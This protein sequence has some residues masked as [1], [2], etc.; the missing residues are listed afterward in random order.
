MTTE[1]AQL[2]TRVGQPAESIVDSDLSRDDLIQL[3]KRTALANGNVPL[4]QGAFHRET[5]VARSALHRAG[6]RTYGELCEL[7]GYARNQLSRR[8]TPSELFDPLAQLTAHLGKF[9]GVADREFARRTGMRIPSEDAI[10][11]AEF[12]GPLAAQLRRYVA[13]KPD[14]GEVVEILA[15]EPAFN[16]RAP[17][18]LAKPVI[19]GHVYLFRY[20]NSG[21]TY[22]IGHS[23]NVERRRAQIAN[24][25]PGSLRREHVIDTD[26]PKGIEEYWKRRFADR[27]VDNKNEIFNLTADDVGAF[28]AR[29]YQ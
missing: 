7:A 22:K 13:D 24:M 3:L 4:G 28:K 15:I 25:N 26:D 20:G 17:R 6:I 29:K 8:L 21:R 10:R 27:L 19:R 23:T 5:H 18:R 16:D 9:P 11:T 12:D 14:Y 2:G 1:A